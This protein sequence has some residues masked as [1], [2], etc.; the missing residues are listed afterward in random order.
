MPLDWNE[1]CKIKDP[2]EINPSDFAWYVGLS[3]ECNE[4]L[5]A[6]RG[7]RLLCWKGAITKLA[8]RDILETLKKNSGFHWYD[9]ADAWP[10]R[11][12]N[13]NPFAKK[14]DFD[15]SSYKSP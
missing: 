9:P 10:V 5:E 8:L 15:S 13:E 14:G 2:M 12:V 7:A 3:C 6:M 1:L 4:I 11:K